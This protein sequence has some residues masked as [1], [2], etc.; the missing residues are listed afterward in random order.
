MPHIEEL[1]AID[2]N[3]VIGRLSA[4]ILATDYV[5]QLAAKRIGAVAFGKH[6]VRF[7][8]HLDFTDDHLQYLKEKL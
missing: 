3:I 4:Q 5:A 6:L 2:T 7:V 8:T 1:Y